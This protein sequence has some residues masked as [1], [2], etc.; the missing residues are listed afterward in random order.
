MNLDD[1]SSRCFF[2]KILS[3][4]SQGIFYCFPNFFSCIVFQSM[5]VQSVPSTSKYSKTPE[6][7]PTKLFDPVWRKIFDKKSDGLSYARNFS[8]PETFRNIKRAP[9][10]KFSGKQEVFDKFLWNSRHRLT[11]HSHRTNGQRQEKY[12]KGSLPSFSVFWYYVTKSF[13][14]TPSHETTILW[15][16]SVEQQRWFLRVLTVFCF[17]SLKF[18]KGK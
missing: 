2:P 5:E 9:G 17:P 18:R 8:I 14:V 10:L 11:K 3:S 13:S 4:R 16:R 15:P 7:P 12:E 1:H 6:H